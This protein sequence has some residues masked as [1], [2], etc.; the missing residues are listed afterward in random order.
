MERIRTGRSPSCQRAMVS[1]RRIAGRGL[2]ISRTRPEITAEEWELF[3]EYAQPHTDRAAC[4]APLSLLPACTMFCCRI[5]VATLLDPVWRLQ[6]TVRIPK[7]GR[8]P[9]SPVTSPC[10]SYTMFTA[11]PPTSR[12]RWLASRM[13]VTGGRWRT[14]FCPNLSCSQACCTSDGNPPS[15]ERPQNLRLKERPESVV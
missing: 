8:I 14:P 12:L 2:R 3:G 7:P 5:G 13:A 9:D 15:P 6:F 11:A 4:A 10:G 1:V